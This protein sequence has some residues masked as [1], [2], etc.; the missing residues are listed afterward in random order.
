MRATA[1]LA[2]QERWLAETHPEVV[3]AMALVRMTFEEYY[4]KR[5]EME[6][7]WSRPSFTSMTTASPPV[8]HFDIRTNSWHTEA[9]CEIAYQGY[10]QEA[11]P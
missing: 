5:V 9:N 6:P 1:C 11:Q 7:L 8:Y 10:Y 3:K 2:A 4:A